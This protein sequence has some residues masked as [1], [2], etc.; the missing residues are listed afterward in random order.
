M[1]DAKDYG[2]KAWK[3]L[4]N[5]YIGKSKPRVLSLYTELTSLQKGHDECITDYVIRAET[6]AA[7]L[8]SAG[9]L[10]LMATL[11]TL[12]NDIR[13]LKHATF[14]SHRSVLFSYFTCLQTT[15]FIFLSLFAVVQMITLKIWERPMSWPAKPS[16]KLRTVACFSSL[17]L[18][19]RTIHEFIVP[20]TWASKVKFDVM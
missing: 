2:R 5:H 12:A 14:L 7:S 3:I 17:D 9:D 8:K 11:A 13:E 18:F 1:R 4:R 10:S 19:S 20:T 6:A 15:T 16:Q